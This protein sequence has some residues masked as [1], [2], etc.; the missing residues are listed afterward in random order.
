[1]TVAFELSARTHV[2]ITAYDI[3]GRPVA[4]LTDDEYA[5][6]THK[7]VWDGRDRH[8]RPVASGVYPIRM[9]TAERTDHQKVVL[10]R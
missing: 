4:V 6:G 5:P 2:R 10:L 1:V 7:T 8:G 3:A 9:V